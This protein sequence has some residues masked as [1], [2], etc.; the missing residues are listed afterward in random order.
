MLVKFGLFTFGENPLQNQIFWFFCTLID[1]FTVK[2]MFLAL[3]CVKVSRVECMAE[4]LVWIVKSNNLVQLLAKRSSRCLWYGT[5]CSWTSL[6]MGV[7]SQIMKFVAYI[8][9]EDVSMVVQGC[10]THNYFLDLLA[11][12][13]SLSQIIHAVMRTWCQNNA[14]FWREW[15]WFQMMNQAEIVI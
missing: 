7:S 9:E 12:I 6:I 5:V 15:H 2:Q 11:L 3:Y 14:L 13:S 8:T 4:L 1:S 10:C